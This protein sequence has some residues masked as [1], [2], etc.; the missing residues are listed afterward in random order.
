MNILIDGHLRLRRK[1]SSSTARWSLREGRKCG[2]IP[3]V[4]MG[5]NGSAA[6]RRSIR[7]ISSP[8]FQFFL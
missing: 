2:A 4:H 3:L 8:D 7:Q 5:G 6:N 1:L